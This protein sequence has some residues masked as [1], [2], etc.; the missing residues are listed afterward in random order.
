MAETPYEEMM[1]AIDALTDEGELLMG[2]QWI[3][4]RLNDIK[5]EQRPTT[6]EQ[7]IRYETAYGEDNPFPGNPDCDCDRCERKRFAL[8]CR[9]IERITTALAAAGITA[10]L[11]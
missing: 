1:R 9:E 4:H 6:L 2:R 5:R 10:P 7:R 8:L 11:P 3:N